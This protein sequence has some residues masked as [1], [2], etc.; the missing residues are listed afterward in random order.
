M[1]CLRNEMRELSDN[2]LSDNE[3]EQVSGGVGLFPAVPLIAILNA[4]SSGSSGGGGHTSTGH[5]ST[6]VGKGQV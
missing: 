2:E 5:T 3:L 4:L 6:N 1:N